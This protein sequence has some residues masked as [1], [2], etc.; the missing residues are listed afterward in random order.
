VKR[1][2]FE[3]R[4]Q[5]N[6]QWVLN[7]P[8]DFSSTGKRRRLF[9]ATKG[10]AQSEAARIRR[11]RTEH[12]TKSEMIPAGLAMDAIKAEKVLAPH[13]ATLLAA[14]KF[15]AVHLESLAQSITVAEL[16]ARHL[17]RIEGK[18]APYQ[19]NVEWAGEKLAARIGRR[20]V[21]TVNPA[22]VEE[23]LT[24]L[25][26]S[27]HGFNTAI[28]YLSPMFSFAVRRGWASENPFGKVERRDTGT[29]EIDFLSVADTKAL[30]AACKDY[31]KK[32]P[33]DW[34][35]HLEVDARDAVVPVALL[36]FAGIR[37]TELTRLEWNDVRLDHNVIRIP[38]RHSK[39]GTTRHV[40]I[41]ENLH[42]WLE[43]VPEDGRTGPLVP[44]SWKKKWQTVRK[45]TGI[46]KRQPD[47]ARHTYAS[48]WL[49]AFDDV[50]A[51]RSRMGHRT[52]DVLF[53]NYRAAVLKKDALAFWEI[54]PDGVEK[55]E[56]MK[57]A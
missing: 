1:A 30:L 23:I 50:N 24:A 5:P 12:G 16:L 6:G 13:G 40:E 29:Q 49:A 2:A 35:K 52:N 26:P 32:H 19:K 57:V 15:Y 41:E 7:V 48:Y 3:P 45:A 47:I 55:P 11:F 46:E 31:R 18:S 22:E 38:A 51:L 53:R 21:A 36:L 54:V 20:V 9:F 42:R 56:A 43:I 25:F 27:A 33:E 39:T 10:K 14:A 44:S 37:P 17:V 8:A 4:E 34:P 28:S